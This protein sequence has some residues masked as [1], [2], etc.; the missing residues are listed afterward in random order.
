VLTNVDLVELF[1][2]E[3]WRTAESAFDPVSQNAGE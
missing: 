1:V 3:L 2:T